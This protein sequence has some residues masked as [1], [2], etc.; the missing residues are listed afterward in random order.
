MV[1]NPGGDRHVIALTG[2][3]GA[4]PTLQPP[5]QIIVGY[6]LQPTG[7][8]SRQAQSAVPRT[9]SFR[10]DRFGDSYTPASQGAETRR[11]HALNHGFAR[12][13]QV[14]RVA[15]RLP[16]TGKMPGPFLSEGKVQY[17]ADV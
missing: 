1:R 14:G 4:G 13:H 8:L 9:V 15:C 6:V 10:R 5:V 2:H 11:P 16:E 12:P 3:H 7:Q 17:P